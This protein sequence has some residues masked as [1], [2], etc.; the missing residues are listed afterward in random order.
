M[1]PRSNVGLTG[2]SGAIYGIRAGFGHK[3]EISF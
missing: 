3:E 2:A 1:P